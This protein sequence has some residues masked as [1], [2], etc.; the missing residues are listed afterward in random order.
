M[1]E[2]A[3]QG[4]GAQETPRV[5]VGMD[6]SEPAQQALEWAGREAQE[7][8]AVLDIRVLWVLPATVGIVRPVEMSDD[9]E[10]AAR[11]I[12]EDAAS[13]ARARW[14]D[15]KV[16]S[17]AVDAP[18]APALVEASQ[19]AALLVVGSRG[20]GGFKGLVLGSVSQH[21]AQHAHCPVMIVRPQRG[22][23]D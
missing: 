9:Y 3:S 17:L 10:R 18:P 16:E 22:P 20:L 8:G 2:T 7:L 1:S 12:A 4:R 13:Y 14:P 15:L 6:G 11:R 23:A 21:C 19:G 5:V